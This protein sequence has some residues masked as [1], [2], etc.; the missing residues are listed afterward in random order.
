MTTRELI[1]QI[2]QGELGLARRPAQSSVPI[3]TVRLQ[4]SKGGAFSLA[5]ATSGL[6]DKEIAGAFTKPIDAGTFSRLKSGTNTLDSDLVSEFCQIVGNT[7]YPEWLAYQVGCT[8][9]MI[10]TEAERQIAIERAAK[11]KAEAENAL[12]RSL[13]VGKAA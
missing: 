1:Y 2:E 6:E 13:L 7:I 5:C 12:L 4:K 8:L 3:E 9:V 10:Q 11:E